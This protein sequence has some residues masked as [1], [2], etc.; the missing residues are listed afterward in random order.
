[1]MPPNRETAVPVIHCHP[2]QSK[3]IIAGLVM[4]GP[5]VTCFALFGIMNLVAGTFLTIMACKPQTSHPDSTYSEEFLRTFSKKLENILDPFK[6][7]GPI[8]LI[9]GFLLVNIGIVLGIIACKSSLHTAQK[10]SLPSPVS[11]F[12]LS[13]INGTMGTR[14]QTSSNFKER[15][16]LC[17]PQR[18]NL[19]KRDTTSFTYLDAIIDVHMTP[20]PVPSKAGETIIK[21]SSA[22]EEQEDVSSVAHGN[23]EGKDVTIEGLGFTEE[24]LF[25]V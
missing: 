24:T 19:G 15:S 12:Q 14:L 7:V 4:A 5:F 2:I 16:F 23:I 25:R 17:P 22:T 21:S 13:D 11:C 10:D 9:T 18:Q 8:L 3:R 6:I 1:M 20:H